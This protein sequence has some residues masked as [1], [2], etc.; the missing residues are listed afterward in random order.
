MYERCSDAGGEYYRVKPPA[1]RERCDTGGS[2]SAPAQ[3]N[4]FFGALGFGRNMDTGDILLY[5]ILY[6]LYLSGDSDALLILM[7]M[8]FT[9]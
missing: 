9:G 1:G 6:M 4:N 7:I 3:S 5:L 8:L 2:K